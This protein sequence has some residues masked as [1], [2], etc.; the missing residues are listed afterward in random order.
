MKT[1]RIDSVTAVL[2]ADIVRD[3]IA[4]IE[5]DEVSYGSAENDAETAMDL[6][7]VLVQLQD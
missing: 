4:E 6:K 3:H 2:L 1:I 5:N 7:A